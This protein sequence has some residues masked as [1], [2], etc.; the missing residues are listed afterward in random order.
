MLWPSIPQAGPLARGRRGVVMTRFSGMTRAEVPMLPADIIESLAVL[1][2]DLM[3][4]LAEALKAARKTMNHSARDTSPFVQ[5]L[6]GEL[7]TVQRRQVL[8]LLASEFPL[9]AVAYAQ[10]RNYEP[11]YLKP[12]QIQV[13]RLL[14]EGRMEE[15]IARAMGISK[16]VIQHHKYHI[17]S[18]LGLKSLGDLIAFAITGGIVKVE[19]QARW[20]GS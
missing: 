17:R 15:E 14:G 8:L 19:G 1:E 2:T 10:R 20:N 12:G 4:A 16:K 9:E 13:L 18:K 7:S 3:E 5:N 11:V 6:I